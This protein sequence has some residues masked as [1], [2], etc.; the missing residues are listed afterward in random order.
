MFQQLCHKLVS[1]VLF[2][3]DFF[4]EQKRPAGFSINRE[5]EF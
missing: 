2:Y 1:V 4:S 3:K 5:Q